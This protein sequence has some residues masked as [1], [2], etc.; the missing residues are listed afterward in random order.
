MTPPGTLAIPGS[1]V[2]G[3]ILGAGRGGD[4]AWYPLAGGDSRPI[5]AR[6]PDG[7]YGIRVSADHRFLLV[8]RDGIPARV[9]RIELA[10]GRQTPWK[11]LLPDD[12]VGVGGAGAVSVSAD[13][14]SYAYGYFRYL[15]DLYLIDGVR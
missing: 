3:S 1:D 4:L 12:P 6:V 5:S 13:G 15:Q 14:T 2:D 11:T 9:D 7:M 10:T 8:G